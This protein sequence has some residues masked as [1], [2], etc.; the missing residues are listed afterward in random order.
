MFFINVPL[1]VVGLLAAAAWLRESRDP[2]ARRL[3]W[4]GQLV[5]TGGLFLLVLALL[6]G[7]TD[8]WGSVAI[9]AELASA[10]V[11]LGAFVAIERR[12]AMPMLP[13]ALFRRRDFAAAQVAA[14]AISASFFALYLYMTLYLQDILHLSALDAG[15]VYM[16]GSLLLFVVSGASAQLSGRIPPATLVAAGL[17]LVAG[18]LRRSASPASARSCRPARRWVTA[19]RMPTSPAF[20]MRCSSERRWQRREPLPLSRSSASAGR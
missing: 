19:R 6:R 5:L 12:S 14:F 3:D 18:G 20:T 16:P 4:P 8:G 17:A 2:N 1:G 9:M 13:L 15:L 11:L 10:L 7:D